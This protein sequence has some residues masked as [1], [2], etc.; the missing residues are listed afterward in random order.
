MVV[1]TIILLCGLILFAGGKKG[2]EKAVLSIL[3]FQGYGEP[4]WVEPFE[5][6]YDA[7]VNVTYAGTVEEHFT[8]TK[9]APGEYNI[10]SND[11]GR[12][13]MYYDAGLIQAIDT[14]KLKNYNWSHSGNRY[15]KAQEL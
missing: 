4:S 13:Q 7:E 14:S 11:S 5:E 9:A 2:A 12:V 6:M 3:C 15:I 10:I 8:K 1:S